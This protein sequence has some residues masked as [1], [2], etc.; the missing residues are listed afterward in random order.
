MFLQIKEIFYTIQG[1]SS[2]A[3]RPCI[4]IRLSGCNLDCNY[5][6]TQFARNLESGEKKSIPEILQETA[7]VNCASIT[8]TGGE[9]LFQPGTIELCRKLIE[10]EYQV[11]VETNGSIELPM[12]RKWR[13]VLD[14]KCPASGMHASFQPTNLNRLQVKDEIKFVISNR[15]D[16][17]WALEQIHKAELAERC[18]EILMS[19]VPG[20]CPPADLAQWILNSTAPVRLQLQLQKII[21]P[22]GEPISLLKTK[23]R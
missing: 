4:F 3:G 10:Q 9:P 1:E 13:A 23:G 14:I 11:A 8:V 21:W 7:K 19:P 12:A 2:S 6:D 16:F 5:C 20:R 22:N 17:D 18:R 15:S